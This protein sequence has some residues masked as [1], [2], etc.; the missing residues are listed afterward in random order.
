M[1]NILTLQAIKLPYPA[2]Y[3]G[4]RK[5]VPHFTSKVHLKLVGENSH[6][7]DNQYKLCYIYGYLKGNT[8]NQIEPYIQTNKIS[9][10][11]VEALIKILEATFGD[12]DEV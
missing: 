6:F 8:Q 9:L 12:P 4:V 10:E 7:S 5:E 11:D 2:D 1:T 3:S